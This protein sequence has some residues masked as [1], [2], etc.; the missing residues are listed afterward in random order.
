MNEKRISEVVIL[1]PLIRSAEQP[2]LENFTI[3]SANKEY[4]FPLGDVQKFTLKARGG[5]IK[6]TFYEGQSNL[7]YILLADGISFNEDL[8]KTK[9]LTVFFQST[10]AGSVLEIL[11]WQ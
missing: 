11:V 2:Y 10:I 7:K 1:D 9:N 8:I 5:A 4:K 3:E 6:V